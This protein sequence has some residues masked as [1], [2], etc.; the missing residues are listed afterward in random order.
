M[1]NMKVRKKDLRSIH[2]KTEAEAE[3]Y[4]DVCNFFF[5]L[6]RFRLRLRLCSVWT[7]PH[8]SRFNLTE[9]LPYMTDY[10]QYY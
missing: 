3:I 4:F 10:I 8:Y 2:T 1:T 9:N 5:D 7:S 6:F